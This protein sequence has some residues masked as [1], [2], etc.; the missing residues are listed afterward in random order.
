MCQEYKTQGQPHFFTP[1][2]ARTRKTPAKVA[3]IIADKNGFT[4]VDQT[5]YTKEAPSG[6]MSGMF[7]AMPN[8]VARII[9]RRAIALRNETKKQ[10]A[11]YRAA[12]VIAQNIGSVCASGDA[13]FD[14]DANELRG[15]QCFIS[16]RNEGRETK[17]A[18]IV[19][20][21]SNAVI[22]AYIGKDEGE[23][24]LKFVTSRDL[25]D[26]F[27]GLIASKLTCAFDELHALVNA[28][29]P[30]TAWVLLQLATKTIGDISAMTGIST[31]RL[32]R[33][34]S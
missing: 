5:M 28:R 23:Y 24:K 1:A 16:V 30:S 17:I 10:E 12:T 18:T 31:Y 29:R 6:D 14:I 26:N 25:G 19:F 13:T 9:Y 4:I 22:R 11:A 34:I 32:N 27:A 21:E 33:M 20:K 3:H 8:D 2:M 15:R 7:A